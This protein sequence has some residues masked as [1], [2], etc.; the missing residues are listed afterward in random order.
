MV[1]PPTGGSLP[2]L[3]ARRLKSRHRR[4]KV[5]ELQDNSRWEVCPG[6]EVLT[7]DWKPEVDI[8]VV[9]GSGAYP[10]HP[11]DLINTET[12]DRVPAQFRGHASVPGGWRMTDH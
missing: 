10:A 7:D 8:T 11:Y 6:H 5:V 9:P 1:E 4:G 3:G 2:H 12:G